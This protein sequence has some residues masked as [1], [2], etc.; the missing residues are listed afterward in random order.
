MSDLP[1]LYPGFEIRRIATG[2]AEI[3]ARTGGSGPPLLLVHGYP[4]SHACWHKIAA[5]LAEHFSVVL[6]DLRGYGASSCPAPD[7]EHN[8]YSKRAMA[9]DL[10]EVME[11]LGHAR[12]RLVGHDRGGRVA[13]R[14]ALDH[15]DRVER[16]AVLDI[17]PTGDVWNA[18]DAVDA[19]GKFHWSFLAQPAPLPE[20]MIAANPATWHEGL[21]ARWSGTGDLSP[22][23]DEA[24]AHYRAAFTQPDRI[25]A[26]CEDY[27]AGA[28]VDHAQDEADRD[29]GHKITC[30]TLAIWGAGRTVGTVTGAE[31]LD[32]WQRWCTD[33]TGGPLPCGHFLAEEAPEE[34]L[35]KVLPFLSGH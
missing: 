18:F 15:G 8:V 7:P 5:R 10:V 6:P 32:V 26:M 21:M 27:R 25:E 12:F 16:L 11:A 29:A 2:G 13:Y 23:S 9:Q 31:P 17:V 35:D 20:A 28:T 14:L 33:V 4:Q 30:P 19:R 3:F 1:E 24:L 34:T 22:F